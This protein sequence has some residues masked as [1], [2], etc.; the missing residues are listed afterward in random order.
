M[1]TEEESKTY[2]NFLREV[3]SNYIKHWNGHKRQDPYKFGFS[4]GGMTPI[5]SRL[6]HAIRMFGL[7]MYP[8]FPVGKYYLDFANPFHRIAL[9]ADGKAHTLP[10]VIVR[11]ERRTKELENAGWTI[12]RFTGRVLN[13]P[14]FE[15]SEDGEEYA[16]LSRFL[17]DLREETTPWAKSPSCVRLITSAEIQKKIKAD[18]KELGKWKKKNTERFGMKIPDITMSYLR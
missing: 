7:E 2:F 6:W 13:A 14:F 1:W 15:E 18:E 10:E 11:D 17:L 3:R 12:Y 5:E 8:Q 16:E 9:E 4:H